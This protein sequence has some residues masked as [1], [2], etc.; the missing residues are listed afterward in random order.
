MR[1]TLAVCRSGLAVAAAV[2]LLSACGGSGNDKSASSSSSARSSAAES[3]ANAAGSDFCQQAATTLSSVEPALTGSENDPATL[4]PALQEAADKVRAIKPPTEI[5]ADWAALADGIE[6][7][8]QVV[9]QQGT[10]DPANA[11]AQQ[12][13]GAIVGKLAAS[14]ASVQTYL[15]EKCGLESPTGTA[16]PTS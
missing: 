8:S 13:I 10:G 16:A 12:Q 3:S 4:G 2:V 14:A 6:Q 9:V 5:S 1:R 11:S 7:I 15:S